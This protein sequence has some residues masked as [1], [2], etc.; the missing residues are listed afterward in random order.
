MPGPDGDHAHAG[1]A[2]VLALGPLAQRQVVDLVAL[3]G[4]PLGEVAVPALGAA[5]GVREQAV[6]DDADP[7]A[8]KA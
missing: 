7:H 4:E 6:V 8:A 1:D 2:R 3:G 5:D